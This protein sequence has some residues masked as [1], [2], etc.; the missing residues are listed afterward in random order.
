MT[1]RL[2][3]PLYNLFYKSLDLKNVLSLDSPPMEGLVKLKANTTRRLVFTY[4]TYS[5][6]QFFLD[7]LLIL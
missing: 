1:R 3:F 2:V 5:I 6:N 7:R 4:M